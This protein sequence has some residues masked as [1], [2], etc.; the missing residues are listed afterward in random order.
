M[1]LI[2]E[3]EINETISNRGIMYNVRRRMYVSISAYL[4]MAA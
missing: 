3:N 1:I 2:R 4:P